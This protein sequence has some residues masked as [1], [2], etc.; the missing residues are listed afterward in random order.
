MPNYLLYLQNPNVGLFFSA[1]TVVL[2]L[3]M[4]FTGILPFVPL[5]ET[6]YE[7]FLPLS[8]KRRRIL[9][10]ETLNLGE[11][12]L[13]WFCDAFLVWKPLIN[14]LRKRGINVSNVI[15]EIYAKCFT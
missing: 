14:H 13:F 9:Q 6:H 12:I 5:K 15:K 11:K 10:V 2:L 8:I 3:L 4:A 7:V 1:R